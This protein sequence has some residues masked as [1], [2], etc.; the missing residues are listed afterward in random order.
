[1]KKGVFSM[2]KILVACFSHSGNTKAL[3]ETIQAIAGGDLFQIRTVETYPAE[4][5][6]VVD[7]AKK[8]QNANSR[9]ELASKVEDMGPYDVVF[10]GYPNWCGTIPMG[11][12]TFLEGYDFSGKT[13]IPFCTH[14]GSALGRSEKDIKR[15][16]PQSTVLDG[17]AVSDSIVRNAQ[18]HVTAWLQK[19]GITQ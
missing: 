11:V 2:S 4:Y 8:E 16:C 18:D 12:F 6:A 9:P 5:N 19:L 14:G 7:V 13:I 3:A 10:V 17:L 1:M 15:L